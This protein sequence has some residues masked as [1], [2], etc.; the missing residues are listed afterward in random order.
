MVQYFLSR[1]D[2][3]LHQRQQ[4]QT[5]NIINENLSSSS[6][7]INNNTI[8]TINNNINNNNINNNNINNNINIK[9]INNNNINNNINIKNINNNNINNNI[10]INNDKIETWIERS[11]SNSTGIVSQSHRYCIG[12]SVLYHITDI[13]SYHQY[14]IASSV[15]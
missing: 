11:E 14:S 1:V 12:I 4:Q 2:I 8:N 3:K 6:N 9:N 15:F 10:S 5:Y 7:V 13:V